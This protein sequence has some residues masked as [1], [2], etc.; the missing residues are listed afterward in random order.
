V[1]KVGKG[2]YIN[3]KRVMC[4][5]KLNARSVTS[6]AMPSMRPVKQLS[7]SLKSLNSS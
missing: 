4:K 7:E 5:E 6:H 2:Q 1:P 3:C